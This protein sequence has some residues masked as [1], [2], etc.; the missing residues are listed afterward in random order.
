MVAFLQVALPEAAT[1][2][3]ALASA[4]TS[5]KTESETASPSWSPKALQLHVGH[6]P[7]WGLAASAASA[8]ASCDD[9]VRRYTTMRI[10]LVYVVNDTFKTSF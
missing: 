10:L 5:P 7:F 8:A 9:Q 6:V 2:T 3:R 1:P 4:P